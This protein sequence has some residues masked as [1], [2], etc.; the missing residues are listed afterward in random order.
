MCLCVILIQR[1]SPHISNIV[2][3]N[4][5]KRNTSPQKVLMMYR[6][7]M[8]ELSP[9]CKKISESTWKWF[10]SS[11]LPNHCYCNFKQDQFLYPQRSAEK[12]LLAPTNFHLQPPPPKPPASSPAKTPGG[13][14]CF[15]SLV[16]SN[17]AC[18]LCSSND[19]SAGPRSWAGHHLTWFLEMN[20]WVSWFQFKI[21]FFQNPYLG[22]WTWSIFD[23]YFFNQQNLLS[24]DY[25]LCNS[26]DT[27]KVSEV[28]NC[29]HVC[30]LKEESAIFQMRI[31]MMDI[32]GPT[33]WAWK[34][35][36]WAKC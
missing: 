35:I 11:Q 13:V 17:V 22:K 7:L 8:I 15:L 33:F 24:K 9:K 34:M 12:P 14:W 26:F 10:T 2:G 29:H 3:C 20:L 36:R 32:F 28:I 25:R 31:C 23:F 4:A 18:G 16:P 30:F 6:Y 21:L 1:Y 5:D 19:R 27:F